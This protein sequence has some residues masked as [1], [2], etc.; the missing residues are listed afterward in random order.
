[1]LDQILKA[2]FMQI[3]F[4]HAVTYILARFSGFKHEEA[5]IVA[6]SAQYVDDATNAGVIEFDNQAMYARIASAHKMLDYDNFDKLANHFAW[7]PFHFLPGNGGYDVRDGH[8]LLFVDKLICRPNSHVARDMVRECVNRRNDKNALHRL[9]IT[10]HVYADTWAHQG[11]V[12]VQHVINRASKI[13]ALGREAHTT[14]ITGRLKNFFG[15]L[16]DDVK[17][18]FV[19][20]CLPLGHGTVLSYPDQPSLRWRYTNGN[21]QVVERNNPDDFLEAADRM[22]AAMRSF[23]L[24]D[25]SLTQP[26]LSDTEKN[27]LQ[28]YITHIAVEDGEMR[29][30]IWLSAIKAGEFSF[31]SV[32]LEYIPKGEGSWKHAALRTE[33][34]ED[35]KGEVFPYSPEFLQSNW[36]CFHDALQ[37]HRLYVL[38]DLL[39]RYGICAA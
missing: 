22:V 10:M 16:F 14:D 29:H 20:S 36:K 18:E 6:Y 9:G 5:D 24:G 2:V 31:G 33:R 19:S 11:F 17:S 38:L 34:S 25:L 30:R 28:N 27:Q 15:G 13:E 12:G 21:G 1:M 7:I 26:G 37:S 35:I 8:E 3:D 39:P 32:E 4:H 23:R